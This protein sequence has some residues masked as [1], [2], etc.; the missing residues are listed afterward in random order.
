MSNFIKTENRQSYF[1]IELISITSFSEKEQWERDNLAEMMDLV[2]VGISVGEEWYS[3][4]STD[5]TRY[6]YFFKAETRKRLGQLR[7]LCERHL[8]NGEEF[9]IAG[10]D[11][12]TFYTKVKQLQNSPD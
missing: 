6:Y 3:F 12:V 2:F 11:K 9:A 4:L 1:S 7:R 8:P 10:L 5:E